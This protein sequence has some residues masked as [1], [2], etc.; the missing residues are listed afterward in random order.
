MVL[1]T[2]GQVKD[3][4]LLRVKGT[5]SKYISSICDASDVILQPLAM[6]HLRKTEQRGRLT[7]EQLGRHLMNI[8]RVNPDSDQE[9]YDLEPS[10]PFRKPHQPYF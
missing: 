2:L 6:D 8:S 1:H 10:L 9:G 7:G 5:R 3:N 4:G